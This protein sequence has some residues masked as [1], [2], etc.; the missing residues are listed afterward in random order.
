MSFDLIQKKLGFGLMRLPMIGEEIDIKASSEM[1]DAFIDA[2]FNYF[3][4]AHG[5]LNGKSESAV[6]SCLSSRYPREAFLLTTKLTDTYFKTESEIRPLFQKQLEACGVDYFDFY[7]MHAQN[8]KNFQKF[9][10][11]NAYEIAFA[12]KKEGKIR[13]VGLSFHDKAEVLDK[14]LTEYPEIEVVQIQFNFMDYE[15]PSIQGRKCYEVCVKHHKPVI[16]MEPIKGGNLVNI[17]ES[18]LKVYSDLGN[19][20]PASY[21]IRYTAGFPDVIMVLSGMSNLDQLKDNISFMKDFI[22]LNEEE[23]SAVAKVRNIILNLNMI[24][25]TTCR[26]CLSECPKNIAIPDL[27]AL[28]NTKQLYQDWNP[29]FYYNTVH[30]S[31]GRKASDCIKCAKCERVCPQHL[32]IRDLLVKVAMEFETS[33]T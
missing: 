4:T 25:C 27:F 18:A 2:G 3:D 24:N 14:I 12:L 33:S 13:H 22:P 20:S 21:A 31:E 5:Y 29:V 8:S 11:C 26:Y 16:I 7:L 17:P 1:V 10:E 15:D 19:A 6:K 28:M 30:T 9:K 23:S 32:P